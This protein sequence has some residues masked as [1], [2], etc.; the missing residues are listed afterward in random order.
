MAK[1]SSRYKKASRHEE[2]DDEP[3]SERQTFL[4]GLFLLSLIFC[5]VL[6][7]GF[8]LMK[9]GTYFDFAHSGD[10]VLIGAAVGFG[11]AFLLSYILTKRAYT[12]AQA[13]PE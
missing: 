12:P 7:T 6:G 10:P 11:L 13:G 1:P 5:P 2:S 9:L 4:S 8:Y 3:L